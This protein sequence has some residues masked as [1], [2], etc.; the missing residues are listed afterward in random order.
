[1]KRIIAF[2]ISLTLIACSYY[3]FSQYEDFSVSRGYEWNSY[4]DSSKSGFALGFVVGVHK[5]LEE[6]DLFIRS[7]SYK[8]ERV[9]DLLPIY[10]I[11]NTQLKEALDNFYRNPVNATIPIKDAAI[12]VCKEIKAKDKERIE[13]EKRL[14]RLPPDEQRVVKRA[15]YLKQEIKRGEYPK[16][17]VTKERVVEKETGKIIPLETEEE[18]VDFWTE[19]VFPEEAPRV[20]EVIKTDYRLVIIIFAMSLVIIALILIGVKRRLMDKQKR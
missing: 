17:E 3:A 4:D 13:K 20:K 5:A 2:L 9:E 6:L 1:M 16:Y 11:T 7:S 8:E 18:I 10:N 15:D 14:L 12:I 19:Q